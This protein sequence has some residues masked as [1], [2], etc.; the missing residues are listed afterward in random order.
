MRKI[1]LILIILPIFF[2][3]VLAFSYVSPNY[4]LL[5]VRIDTSKG[6]ANSWGYCLEH[7]TIGSIIGGKSFSANYSLDATNVPYQDIR[8]NPPTLNPVTTPTNI[9]PQVLSGTKD[10]NTSIYINGYEAMPINNE[11]D[12]SCSQTLLEGDNYLIITARSSQGL[13]SNPVYAIITLDTS[14]PTMPVVTDDGEATSSTSQLHASWTSQ[15]LETGI[16]EYQYSIGTSLGTT[17]IVS[18]TPVGINTEITKADLNLSNGQAYYFNV[19]AKNNAGSWSQI[20]SSDG[21]TVNQNPPVMNSISPGDGSGFYQQDTVTISADAFDPDGDA[22]EYQF[23]IGGEIRQA[24]SQFS[25]YEW[26]V[27]AEEAGLHT[28]K[29]EVR[30]AAAG[31]VSQTAELYIFLKPI[32]LPLP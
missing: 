28:I 17:D 14:P 24:W 21:I 11:T 26:A 10:K 27:L 25:T 20:G 2:Y 30:D 23:S 3:T 5:D 12:W 29:V 9:T 19:K 32:G 31:I 16:V 8:P 1:L 13:E 22:L 7:V 4:S 6:K 15:D 18:W